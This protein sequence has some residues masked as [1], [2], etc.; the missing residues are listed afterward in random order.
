MEYKRINYWIESIEQD[1]ELGIQSEFAKQLLKELKEV[2]SI[3]EVNRSFTE[4]QKK[5]IVGFENYILK[6]HPD[7]DSVLIDNLDRWEQ[8]V[9][10]AENYAKQSAVND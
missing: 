10:L 9:L 3:C 8:I 2:L 5:S 4:K 7:P 6:V 1:V